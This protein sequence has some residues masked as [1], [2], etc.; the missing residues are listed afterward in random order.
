MIVVRARGAVSPDRALNSS[1]ILQHSKH[2][3]SMKV[4]FIAW[5]YIRT[6]V[7]L[8]H[9][10][11]CHFLPRVR[12]A[13]TAF[14]HGATMPQCTTTA[15]RCVRERGTRARKVTRCIGLYNA[16]EGTIVISLSA[17]IRWTPRLGTRYKYPRREMLLRQTSE[18][19][20]APRKRQAPRL[21]KHLVKDKP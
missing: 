21:G 16:G 14:E 13:S 17:H 3:R 1:G 5:R 7:K 11:E 20:K 15:T 10:K 12:A 18:V 19:R 2:L 8:N 9:A 6:K 4:L